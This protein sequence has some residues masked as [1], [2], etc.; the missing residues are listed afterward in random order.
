MSTTMSKANR[1]V[2]VQFQL[3]EIIEEKRPRRKK[4]VLIQPEIECWS[5]YSRLE[6]KDERLNRSRLTLIERNSR[7]SFAYHRL[8]FR[9]IFG[10]MS[11]LDQF[12]QNKHSFQC[13][14]FLK[15][16]LVFLDS[17]FRSFGQISFSNNPLSGLVS[18]D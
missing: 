17:A 18:E 14:P 8:T 5:S 7:Q 13:L 3:D 12:L 2:T 16:I 4:S 6:K 9:S 11:H 1:Q 10:T 15:S